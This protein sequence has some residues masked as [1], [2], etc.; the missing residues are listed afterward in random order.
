MMSDQVEMSQQPLL[1]QEGG[2][3]LIEM[4]IGMA[5]GLVI[6]AGLTMVFVCLNDTSRAISSRT[7]R[8]GDLFLA[9]QVMQGELRQ[10]LSAELSTYTV[11]ADLTARSVAAIPGYP[12]SFPSLPHWDATTKTITYQDLDGNV[13]IFQYQRTS[14]DRIYWLRPDSSV[15]T[16]AELMRDLNT[17]TGLVV[18]TASGVMTVKLS[19]TYTNEDKVSKD[20]DITFK[21]R[22]RN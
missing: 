2:F 16:F 3:T 22:P 7:E 1:Q 14:N 12:G 5:M 9:S 4:L 19:S 11:A 8:M 15:S 20:L 21:T 10:S 6:L 18:T 13:G 17:S